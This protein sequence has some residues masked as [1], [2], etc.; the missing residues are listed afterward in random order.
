MGESRLNPWSVWYQSLNLSPLYSSVLAIYLV[1]VVML[2]QSCYVALAGLKLMTLLPQLPKY[3]AAM[4]TV[5]TIMGSS[6]SPY[7]LGAS[8]PSPFAPLTISALDP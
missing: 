1:G 3:P 8:D 5:N 7:L 6:A 4:M 2:R